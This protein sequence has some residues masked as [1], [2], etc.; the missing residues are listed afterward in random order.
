MK[1]ILFVIFIC[2]TV[3]ALHAQVEEIPVEGKKEKMSER[4]QQNATNSNKS[5]EKDK[6]AK[7]KEYDI[8][9]Y[10]IITHERD[11]ILFDTTL[12]IQKEYKFNYLRKDEFEL[13]PFS[14]LGQT[15]NNLG[16]SFDRP[17]SFPSIGMRAKHFNYDEIEDVKYFNVPTPTTELFFKTAMEQGQLL[18]A[19][20][21]MNTSKRMNF[22]IAYKGMR[23]LGKYQNIL[24]STGNFKF[25]ANY[26]TKNDRYAMRGHFY[27]QDVLNN[28]NGG[29]TAA[30]V[31][32]FENGVDEFTDRSRLSV[33]YQD[34]QNILVGKRYYVDHDYKILKKKDSLN[35]SNLRVGH[36]FNYETKYYIFDQT[37][38]NDQFGE[39]YVAARIRD[40]SQLRKLF[41][42]G[43]L[44]YRTKTF[45]DV[46]FKANHTKYEYFFDKILYQANGTVIPNKIEGDVVSVGGEWQHTIA[47][48]QLKADLL[49]NIS[50]EL[51]GNYFNGRAKYK[52][53]DDILT[54]A[55]IVINSKAPNFNFI[56]NQSDY[57]SYNWRN[58][59]KN[60]RTQSLNFSVKSK[61]WFNADVSFTS[62]DNYT[63]FSGLT[64]GQQI[65]PQ[66]SEDAIT[67]LK[68][69]FGKEFK[70]GKFAL[71]NTV[72][73]QKVT[74][75]GDVFN[76]PELVTRNTLY[77]TDKWFKKALFIQTGVTFSYF[78]EYFANGYSP[79][80][81]ETYSQN[82]QKIGG[83]PRFDVFI[84]AKVRRTRIYFKLEH[85]N[86]P[87]TGYNFFSAPN[88]P[89]RDF[90]VRFGLVW[91][92]FS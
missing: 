83:F 86:S 5:S 80:L 11:T 71:N 74:Q 72:M 82:Q 35:D 22:S 61:K 8:N 48:I 18:D 49:A 57:I 54:E 34:A 89:Y 56:V 42:E 55:S 13:L 69:K 65:S 50:G 39:S 43:S 15:Y 68:V 37:S 20:I 44:S 47:G 7:R 62:M 24:S 64:D 28:E 92:F 23:S 73:Y 16:Y 41:N 4:G 2:I 59:L 66:Q 38:Q 76:V 17:S 88:Y 31:I 79:L 6:T 90:I 51:G 67:Y 78:T 21:T 63:Y 30:A 26:R 33:A 45:G 52:F 77:Y 75:T 81:G 91:N 36:T 12:T 25:T 58:N 85:L 1:Y 10:K 87:F 14:N 3:P 70:Y 32:D 84:N 27:S 46:K 60:E 19:F 40:R 9:L 29:I 53:N